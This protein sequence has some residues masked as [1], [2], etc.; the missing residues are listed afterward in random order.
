M[1]AC[2][3]AKSV[4]AMFLLSAILMLGLS[5]GAWAVGPSEY[6]QEISIRIYSDFAQDGAFDKSYSQTELR[7]YLDDPGIDHWGHADIRA[8]L[9]ALVGYLVGDLPSRP[10]LVTRLGPATGPTAGGN[11]VV[12]V[13]SNFGGATGVTFGGI[14]ATS[15]TVNSYWDI[16]AVAPPHARGTVDVQVVGLSQASMNS[17]LDDYIYGPAMVYSSIR[18]SE[19]YD[20]A[21][22]V[23]KAMFPAPLP[24]GSGVVLAPGVTFQEALCGAPLASAW[25]GPVLLNSTT[26]LYGAVHD[27]LVRLAP[28]QVFCIGLSNAVASAVRAALPAAT[29]TSINGANVYAMSRNVANALKT[30]VGDMST[31]TAIITIGTNFPDAIGVA[32]LACAEL[33]PIILTDKAAGPTAPPLHASASAALSDLGITKALRVGTY[34]SLPLGVTMVGSCSGVNRYATNVMVANWAAANAG[35]TYAHT[36]IATGDKFPDA[37]ASGPYLAKDGGILLLSPLLGPLQPVTGALITA[38]R[39]AVQRVTFI[40]MVEPVIGQVK[41][42]VTPPST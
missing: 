35:L 18:G 29:V 32:P 28:A 20:T 40:A 5:S 23:S 41:A 3:R 8:M 14:N 10:V 26:V 33:W 19:R 6:P 36:G 34:A 38:N 31:A 11:T 12:I 30:K 17:R 9:D 39:A 37:L 24:P 22:R 2:S 25:G 13:G 42:L 21:L 15:F 1:V 4:V 27:E 7:T 16:T